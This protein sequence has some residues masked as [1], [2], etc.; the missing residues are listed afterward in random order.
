MD[1]YIKI[2]QNGELSMAV[3]PDAMRVV[4]VGYIIQGLK[5]DVATNG[6]MQLTRNATPTKLLKL[7]TEYT[8]KKYRRTQKQE[9]INDLEKWR[10]LMLLGLPM[11]VESE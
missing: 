1:D 11:F 3:G 10:N 7:A 6:R 4:R 8:G 2:R 5:M 9:A